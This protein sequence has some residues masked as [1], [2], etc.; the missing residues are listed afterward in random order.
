MTQKYIFLIYN[1]AK[2]VYVVSEALCEIFG[3]MKT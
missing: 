1:F 3:Y 2:A